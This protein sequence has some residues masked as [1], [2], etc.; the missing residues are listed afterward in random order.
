MC[1]LTSPQKTSFAVNNV[2]RR[3]SCIAH[4]SAV[5]F[6]YRRVGSGAERGMCK[7][8]WYRISDAQ[9]FQGTALT[10]GIRRHINDQSNN[11]STSQVAQQ[12]AH[13]LA[14]VVEYDAAGIPPTA[15]AT[16]SASLR[17]NVSPKRGAGVAQRK[18]VR[19]PRTKAPLYPVYT[20]WV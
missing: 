10:T 19:R 7:R 17:N 2:G 6:P 15:Q 14:A 20:S 16:M 8:N 11:I 13:R 3:S 18:G 4:R 5:G 9:T 12:R 1:V